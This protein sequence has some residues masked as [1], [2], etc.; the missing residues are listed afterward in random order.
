MSGLHS[1]K[2]PIL[3]Q[4]YNSYVPHRQEAIHL[5]GFEV[6]Y[7][8]LLLLPIPT[9][10]AG[11][12]KRG[13]PRGRAQAS[14]MIQ[15]TTLYLVT[16]ILSVAF[17]YYWLTKTLPSRLIADQAP[18][19]RFELVPVESYDVPARASGIEWVVQPV[20]SFNVANITSIIFVHSL[21]SN[22][23]TTWRARKSANTSHPTEEIPPNSEQ[24]VNWV[25]DFLPS[26]LPQDVRKDTRIFFYNYDSYWKRDAVYTRLQTVSSSLLEHINGQIRQ[27][28]HVSFGNSLIPGL[29]LRNPL[30]GAGSIFDLRGT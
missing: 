1:R 3:P 11:Q 5:L 8:P 27:S 2:P 24:Y 22:P 14:A 21:G 15:A 4:S 29:L 25:S 17:T 26:D 6:I 7:G 18:R 9:D 13:D 20:E 23:D 19:S 10:F 28:K 16:F 30:I 12:T